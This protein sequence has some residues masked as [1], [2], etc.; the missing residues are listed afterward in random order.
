MRDREIVV[1]GGG[2]AGCAAAA[3]LRTHGAA[4]TLLDANA[5][6]GGRARSA[7]LDGIAIDIGAQ[8]L[9]TSYARTLRLLSPDMA[10]PARAS[11]RGRPTLPGDLAASAGRDV[12]VRSGQRY[13]LQ[14]GSL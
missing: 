12:F 8:L 11:E 10:F 2:F 1:I 5:T 3:A 14:L 6:L 9:A 4:V 7:E 13:P